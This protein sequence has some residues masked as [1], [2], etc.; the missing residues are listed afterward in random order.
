MLPHSGEVVVCVGGATVDSVLLLALGLAV[1]THGRD[2]KEWY[3]HKQTHLGISRA[4]LKVLVM[5]TD[6]D[7]L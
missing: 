4:G 5:P 7:M 2:S 3:N 1:A 6:F